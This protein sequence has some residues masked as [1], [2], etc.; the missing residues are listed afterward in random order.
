MYTYTKRIGK[1]IDEISSEE[2]LMAY[3]SQH[4]NE[5]LTANKT[6]YDYAERLIQEN[7]ELA[8]K[9]YESE[10][11]Y[12]AE[13]MRRLKQGQ[14]TDLF[15]LVLF[16]FDMHT[17]NKEHSFAKESDFP[18]VISSNFISKENISRILSRKKVSYD[19]LKK[20]L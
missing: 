3:I 1:A 16:D 5:F 2:D 6:A 12:Q 19:T 18:E 20:I 7:S 17:E 15:L 14:N 9:I 8:A 4:K 11:S 10:Y 13:N